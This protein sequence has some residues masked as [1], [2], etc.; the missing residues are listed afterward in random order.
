MAELGNF[1]DRNAARLKKA[2]RLKR[3]QSVQLPDPMV[4][5]PKSEKAAG[6]TPKADDA[7]P[8]PAADQVDAETASAPE[9]G[10][11]DTK[12][13]T[14]PDPAIEPAQELAAEPNQKPV[15]E[16]E[17]E[18]ED[19]PAKEGKPASTEKAAEA[20]AVVFKLTFQFT[21]AMFPRVEAVAKKLGVKPQAILMKAAK[22]LKP[23]PDDFT[24][25]EEKRRVGPL[26]RHAFGIPEDSAKAWIKA[27][28]PLNLAARPG[29]VLRTVAHNA[30]DR[31]ADDLLKQL[32][33][34]KA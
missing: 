20:Q 22:G 9:P 3:A 34:E 17:P 14:P 27:Q 26:F 5:Y 12:A 2:D 8:Q 6:Y 21:E 29:S 31:V 32:E 10:W 23:I 30:F 13:A 24:V 25:A 4:G 18:P 1:K 11:D 16:P 33:S 7:P 19:K 15:P 28:D